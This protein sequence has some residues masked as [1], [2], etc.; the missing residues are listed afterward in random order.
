MRHFWRTSLILIALLLLSA[1]SEAQKRPAQT[2]ISGMD[3]LKQAFRATAFVCYTPSEMDPRP[4]HL[5]PATDLGIRAD[6]QTLHPY[7]SG[8]VTYSCSAEQGMD[9]IVP[10]AERQGFQVI[11]GVWDVKSVTE[12]ETAVRLAR[13]Y[14]KTV[15]AVIIGNET[16]LS[17]RADW[18]SL[19]AAIRLVRAALPGMPL[20]TSEPI[21]SYGNPDLRRIVDFHSPIAHWIFQGGDSQDVG[22]AI[23]WARRRIA[24][25]QSQTEGGKPILIK[26]SGL[27]SGPAPFSPELQEQYWKTWR[28]GNPNTAQCATSFWEAFDA[29]WKT[30]TNPSQLTA[31]EAHWGGWD[32]KRLPKRV[33]QSLPRRPETTGS[34]QAPK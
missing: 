28:A 25:L 29:P 16:Q 8:I 14:P 12:L 26:E 3:R 7:F 2:A 23:Q 15:I 5:K 9:R 22:Q 24:A 19:E 31:T 34:H 1:E 30:E 10:L 13:S 17:G 27:P 20:S 4:G 18:A 11:L 32:E 21:S 6:L 33:I